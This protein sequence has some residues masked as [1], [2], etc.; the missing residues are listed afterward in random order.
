[1]T[2]RVRTQVV[3]T[4]GFDCLVTEQLVSLRPPFPKVLSGLTLPVSYLGLTD[5]H[6]GL[7]VVFRVD[8]Y[9]SLCPG[10]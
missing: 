7:E 1:M 9:P 8:I 2:T 10:F 4:F 6:P 5:R 3:T